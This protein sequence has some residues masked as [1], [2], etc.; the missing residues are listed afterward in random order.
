M[1]NVKISPVLNPLLLNFKFRTYLTR[2][3]T[4]IYDTPESFRGDTTCT[5]LPS[6]R[7]NLTLVADPGWEWAPRDVWSG[8]CRLRSTGTIAKSDKNCER[9]SS[10]LSYLADGTFMG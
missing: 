5:L 2:L 8:N 9:G 4:A 7:K 6:G 3:S 10:K 1:K